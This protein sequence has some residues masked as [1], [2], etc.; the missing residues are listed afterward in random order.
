ME[1]EKKEKKDRTWMWIA[2]VLALFVFS[3]F[4][5][6]D[7]PAKSNT[8]D[9][10]SDDAAEYIYGGVMSTNPA[11]C[12]NATSLDDCVSLFCDETCLELKQHRNIQGVVNSVN[13]TIDKVD[14]VHCYCYFKN[15]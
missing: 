2:G 9:M 10:L 14:G 3:L 8:C 13:Y 12:E 11:L 4:F 7:E 1:K 5:P 6:T 15:G